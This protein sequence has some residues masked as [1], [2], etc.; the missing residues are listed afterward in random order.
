MQT[1]VFGDLLLHFTYNVPHETFLKMIY[2][3]RSIGYRVCDGDLRSFNSIPYNSI[4]E[5]VL[6][7]PTDDIGTVTAI[8]CE[9]GTSVEVSPVN[10]VIAYDENNNPYTVWDGI[11]DVTAPCFQL[12][13]TIDEVEYITPTYQLIDGSCTRPAIWIESEFTKF[14]CLGRWY[15][16]PQDIIG[17]DISVR[18]TNGTYIWGELFDM[19]AEHEFTLFSDCEVTKSAKK[20]EYN[21]LANSVHSFYVTMIDAILSRG[22]IY[23]DKAKTKQYIVQNGR[24]FTKIEG[25][26]RSQF[27][28]LIKLSDCVCNTYIECDNSVEFVPECS[29]NLTYQ[30]ET[31]FTTGNAIG[32]TTIERTDTNEMTFVFSSNAEAE[33]FYDNVVCASLNY[34]LLIYTATDIYQFYGYFITNVNIASNTVTF[35]YTFAEPLTDICA[36]TPYIVNNDTFVIDE[37]IAAQSILSVCT[38]T[39]IVFTVS[40]I[41]SPVVLITWNANTSFTQTSP[42]TIEVELTKAV[43]DVITTLSVDVT[44]ITEHCGEQSASI[45]ADISP[46]PQLRF[47]AADFSVTWNA[48]TRELSVGS[49]VPTVINTT[50]ASLTWQLINIGAGYSGGSPLFQVGGLFVITGIGLEDDF[51]IRQTLTDIYGNV[52]NSYLVFG[53]NRPAAPDE[54]FIMFAKILTA[55]ISGFDVDILTTYA[56]PYDTYE[57]SIVAD[58]L[59]LDAD[60]D[61]IYEQTANAALAPVLFTHAYGVAGSY[62]GRVGVSILESVP[63]PPGAGTYSAVPLGT[64]RLEYAA[65]IF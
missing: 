39:K 6:Y 24:H 46:E 1:V 33:D 53:Q 15:G 48:G 58:E 4:S 11:E 21:V 3:Q 10:F 18:F 20:N 55:S 45:S 49:G 52:S 62:Q 27:D 2:T 8:D 14:D 44:A 63:P 36:V 43:L 32:T 37:L 50:I 7:F 42:T 65:Q 59:G 23:L 57:Y 5:I 40:V 54:D 16:E 12:V 13:F 56:V 34:S 19:G 31:S 30:C 61:G 51:L 38:G 25:F 28:M 41:G 22:L 17:G 47:L 29:I 35:D 26:C 60:F 9:T 64:I